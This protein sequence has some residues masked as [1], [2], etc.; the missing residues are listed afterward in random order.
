MTAA[1]CHT[2]DDILKLKAALWAL[3]HFGSTSEGLRYLI[4]HNCLAAMIVLAQD[5]L[6]FSIR[7]TSY[8]SLGLI[9]TTRQG[10]DEL[11][12]LG[13][14]ARHRIRSHSSRKSSTGWFCTRHNRHIAWPIIEEEA[15]EDDSDDSLRLPCAFPDISSTLYFFD[16]GIKDVEGS[17]D[18]D[19]SESLVALPGD[20]HV[21]SEFLHK[22]V[23]Q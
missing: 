3:G 19:T 21:S 1:S 13:K 15:W 22:S 23:F 14:S 8:Y 6:V 12:K 16:S 4:L 11:F 5:C 2:E 7:A 9:A 10:A 20:Y 18:D 17:T